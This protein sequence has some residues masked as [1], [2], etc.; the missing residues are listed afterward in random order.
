MKVVLL[1]ILFLVTLLYFPLNRQTPKF[2]FKTKFDSHIP[3]VPWTVW[4]YFL[5]YFLFPTSIVLTWNSEYAIPLLVTMIFS[6]TIASL[7]WRLFPNGVVRPQIETGYNHNHRFLGIIYSHD[8]DCNGLP[9]GHVLHSFVAC[10]F[11]AKLFPHIWMIFVIILLA[12]S[13]STLTT[14]Q[15]YF[16]DMV[17][18]LLLAP[19]IIEITSLLV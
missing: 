18:T 19:V 3:L 1:L 4:I 2:S 12:I 15:H 11:L 17:F 16:L 8:K 7:F 13:L 6:T 9:S 10:F 5:Y 14:K